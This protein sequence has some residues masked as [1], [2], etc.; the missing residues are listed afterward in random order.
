M[1][2]KDKI[3]F[4]LSAGLV[5]LLV[6][7]VLFDFTIAIQVGRPPDDGIIELLKMAITGLVGVIAGYLA[8]REK[9]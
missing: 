1:T 4:V 9:K 6:L 7:I 5:S 3:I 8:G 2:P